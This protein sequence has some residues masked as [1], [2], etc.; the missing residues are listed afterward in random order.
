MQTIASQGSSFCDMEVNY[1]GHDYV[2]DPGFFRTQ[3]ENK[4]SE[5]SDQLIIL[6]FQVSTSTGEG[7]VLN[8]E[9]YEAAYHS[10][11]EFAFDWQDELGDERLLTLRRLLKTHGK[12]LEYI[13]LD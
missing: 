13:D 9:E 3:L 11:E 12:Q 8:Q 5:A 7:V 2:R 1:L 10:H 4:A 6:S